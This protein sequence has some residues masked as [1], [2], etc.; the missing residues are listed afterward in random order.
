MPK[1]KPELPVV[2]FNS[3]KA[4]KEFER[5]LNEPVLPT[6]NMTLAEREALSARV[7]TMNE[8]I[9]REP[10]RMLTPE[11]VA[12]RRSGYVGPMPKTVAEHAL[13][14][15]IDITGIH[16]EGFAQLKKL[17]ERAIFDSL[18]WNV[19]LPYTIE[20]IKKL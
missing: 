11:E 13:V 6:A 7:K 1:K 9:A 12:E 14:V 4:A 19:E 3:A 8:H 17:I 20:E 10:F 15:R 2:R 5:S 16:A 18:R